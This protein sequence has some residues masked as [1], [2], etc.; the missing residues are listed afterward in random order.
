VTHYHYI[1]ILAAQSPLTKSSELYN[2]G[3]YKYRARGYAIF[4]ELFYSCGGTS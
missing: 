3:E 4:I 1:N 2:H